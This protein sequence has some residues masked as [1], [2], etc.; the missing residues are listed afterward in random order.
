MKPLKYTSLA[1][2]VVAT[3]QLT[4]CQSLP[5]NHTALSELP[6]NTEHQYPNTRSHVAKQDK[7]LSGEMG[8]PSEL[9]GNVVDSRI[10]VLSNARAKPETG[11]EKHFGETVVDKYRWLEDVDSINPEYL[12][13]TN[14][15]RQRNFIG[16]LVENDRPSGQLDNRTTKSLQHLNPA[17]KKSEVTEWVDA[18]NAATKAYF[19]N[20]PI[21]AQLNANAKSLFDWEWS[22]RK[23][24]SEK[25]GELHFLR[26]ADGYKRVIRTDKEGKQTE[27]WRETDLDWGLR[28]IKNDFYPS[29]DNSY[30][31]MVL[32]TGTSDSDKVFLAVFDSTTGKQIFN[33]QIGLALD[34]SNMGALW[35]DDDSFIYG[36]YDYMTGAILFRHDIGKKRLNDPI[37]LNSQMA[38]GGMLGLPWLEGKDKRYLVFPN[39]IKALDNAFLIQDTK[40]GKLYRPYDQ[41]LIDKHRNYADHFIGGKFVAFDETT[42]DVWLISG[43]NDD[44]RGEI[45]KTNLNHLKKREVVVPVND[46]YDSILEAVYHKEGEG[47]FLI[48]YIKDGQHK[49]ILTDN[50]GK[51]LRDLTP[52]P[53]GNADNLASFVAGE[54]QSGNTALTTNDET[55]GTNYV[56][57][58]YQNFGLPR[59]VYKYDLKTGE[60]ID[61]RRRDLYP[62]A[63]EDYTSELVKYKSKDGTL[64]PMTITYKKGM[65]K[66]GKNPT[67]LM[68]YGGF[69]AP[70]AT[71]FRPD[72]ALFLEAGGIFAQPHIRGGNEYGNKWHTSG[73]LKNK[74]NSFDDFESAADY[75]HENGYT[76]PAHTAITG[77]SNGGLL[78]GAAMTLA[79]HKYGVAVPN[80]AVL[81]MF[82][83][84]KKYFIGQWNGE[85]GSVHDNREMYNILKAY[86]PY[87]NVKAGVCYPAT[88]VATSKRDDRVV[89]FHSYKF[90][91]ILQENQGCNK[92]TYLYAH[93]AYGHGARETP[94]R[95]E[96]ISLMNSFMLGEMGIKSVAPAVRPN[97]E[98]LKGEKWL[99]EEAEEKA[100]QGK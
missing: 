86:S 27:L 87:H 38:G 46:Q 7:F 9:V 21:F 47:Y 55:K 10:P 33:K 44:Q 89:P 43:E 11:V 14:A 24:K 70:N 94:H 64:I 88:L 36:T 41:K 40:T 16:T 82:S 53:T 81:D 34:F 2:A 90:T 63:H 95:I 1:V 8:R 84:D 77:A 91:A 30:F 18:Q 20:S 93:E 92:P 3:M 60:F 57:F 52:A 29:T 45:V 79:P 62:F 48:K 35:L 23:A 74:F 54:T 72:M 66:N 71:I 28:D 100:K 75:L 56:T 26:G 68:S 13:E 98:T 58:R 5:K 69:S 19:A 76:S 83:A 15:D 31:A 42:G 85:Y 61:I 12:R 17:A 22:I 25:M 96:Y 78:V 4:Q 6:K 49:V 51:V 50:Q 99:K 37:I 73:N 65:V 97:I 32:S 67:M 59:T 80:V 39:S